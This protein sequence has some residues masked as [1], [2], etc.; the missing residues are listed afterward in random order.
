MIIVKLCINSRI[1]KI[2][3]GITSSMEAAI[4]LIPER[5]RRNNGCNTKSDWLIR[6]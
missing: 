5:I 3:R 2:K 1:R 6:L 4:L